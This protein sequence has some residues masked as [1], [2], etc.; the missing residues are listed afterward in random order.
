ML[1]RFITYTHIHVYTYIHAFILQDFKN[2]S[3]FLY[4]RIGVWKSQTCCWFFHFP[5]AVHSLAGVHLFQPLIRK[6]SVERGKRKVACLSPLWDMLS[7]FSITGMIFVL[8]LGNEC[9]MGKYTPSS[10]YH[11]LSSPASSKLS[12]FDR[13]V[14][15]DKIT[16]FRDSSCSCCLFIEHCLFLHGNAGLECP[17]SRAV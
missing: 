1:M 12:I 3:Y 7:V 6:M 17:T 14:F 15:P 10:S 2:S 16:M 5:F 8:K 13:I 9:Q 4:I 11:L